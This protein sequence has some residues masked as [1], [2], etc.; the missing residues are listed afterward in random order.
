[1]RH[2]RSRGHRFTVAAALP[3]QERALAE[4]LAPFETSEPDDDATCYELHAEPGHYR[5]TVDGV[6]LRESRDPEE[7]LEMLLWRIGEQTVAAERDRLFL[8][9]G[10]VAAGD[11]AVLL[12]A[13]SGSG[14]STTTF[15]L[16]QSGLGYLSDEYAVLDPGSGRVGPFPRAL[17]LKAGTRRAYPEIEELAALVPS[18]AGSTLHVPPG[19]LR[20][21]VVTDS[22]PVGWVVFPRYRP[23]T[24]T[25]L[26][27]LS[28]AE[29]CVWLLRSTF[30]LDEHGTDALAPLA[31]IAEQAPGHELVTADLAEAVAAVRRLVGLRP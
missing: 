27:P 31:A 22:L 28:K 6:I 18:G 14:K 20:G 24:S 25:T 8:H 4:L 13:A 1:V 11:H 26:R 5:L 21:P 10:V 16:V 3:E 19:R 17:T 12:P 30:R 9:S 2:F 29:T 23:G 15:G 7:P